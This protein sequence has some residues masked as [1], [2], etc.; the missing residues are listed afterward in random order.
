MTDKRLILELQGSLYGCPSP[1]VNFFEQELADGPR[2]KNGDVT[3]RYINR[4]LKKYRGRYTTEDGKYW[5]ILVFESEQD[6]LFF[7]LKFS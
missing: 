2:D 1:W 6:L 7:K 5:G 3:A 4:Q